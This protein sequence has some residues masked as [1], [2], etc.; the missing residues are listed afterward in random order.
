MRRKSNTSFLEW[1]AIVGIIASIA[2]LV[3]QLAAYSNVRERLP[4][5]MVIGGVPV[6]GL[7]RQEAQ[8]ELQRI[9]SSPI[10][11]HYRNAVFNLDPAQIS[12]RMDTEVMLTRADT[13][14][15]DSNFWGG[16]WDYLWRQPGKSVEVTL[17]AEYSE[18]Q[19]RNYLKDVARRYDVA[20]TGGVGDPSS[21]NF[22]K[23]QPGVTLEINSSIAV[24]DFALRQPVN[25]RA[26][27]TIFEGGTARPPITALNQT[28][29]DYLKSKDFKGVASVVVI[30]LRSGQEIIIN[31]DVA[32]SGAS[33]MNMP[34]LMQ[35]YMNWGTDIPSEINTRIADAMTHAS[36]EQGNFLLA[37]VGEG[38]V[39]RGGDRINT[40]LRLLGMQNTFIAKGFNQQGSGAFIKTP[41]NKRTD[42]STKPDP[43]IQATANDI[44][45][46]LTMIYQCASNG[47]G[48]FALAFP[49]QI[50]QAEC[51]A[52]ISVMAQNQTGALIEGGVPDGVRVAHKEGLTDNTYGDAAIV[53]SPN[54]DYILVQYIWTPEFLKWEYG[55]TLMADMSRAVYN[56]FN[57]PPAGQK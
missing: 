14:R 48:A 50:T 40:N 1:V 3:I 31:P 4:V 57:Q 28:L 23:G 7:T 16:F 10:E 26:A 12:F 2:L 52:M 36:D 42:L 13:Y 15:S 19:L 18:T 34:I 5:G 53:F 9:Y 21:L 43:Y 55:S 29:N 20:P 8:S 25:R 32:F 6:G 30:D 41:A 51:Q 38:N 54:G 49:T 27:L 56:Y 46:L 37:D 47:G 11:L 33:V 35:T 17:K 24:I 22:T 39:I 44:A 45:S